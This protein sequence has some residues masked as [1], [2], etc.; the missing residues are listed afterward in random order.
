MKAWSLMGLLGLSLS[1]HAQIKMDEVWQPLLPPV[2]QIAQTLQMHPEQQLTAQ[3]QAIWSGKAAQQ[4]VGSAAWVLKSGV[5][6]RQLSGSS[7]FEQQLGAEKRLRLPNKQRADESIANRQIQYAD[8]LAGETSHRISIGLLEDWWLLVKRAQ[9]GRRIAQYQAL[10]Q[11]QADSVQKR[12]QAGDAARLELMLIQAEIQQQAL[13]QQRQQAEL[14]QQQLRLSRYYQGELPA[15]LPHPVLSA[16]LEQQV[17]VLLAS[18]DHTALLE[19][20]AAQDHELQLAS[21]SEQ[22]LEQQRL[23]LALESRPDP[24]VSLGYSREQRGQ[25]HLISIGLSLPLASPAH[26]AEQA[27]AQAELTQAQIQ[28][29]LLR[30]QLQQEAT[31]RIEQLKHAWLARGQAKQLL[32]MSEQQQQ[33]LYRAYQLGEISLNDWLISAR[34]LIQAQQR[35]DEMEQQL[36]ETYSRLR[37]DQHQLWQ[38]DDGHQ[39]AHS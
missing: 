3:H 27:V 21:L 19:H 31:A 8:R 12:I 5:Q 24:S 20:I 2:A 13:E 11:K 32:L 16:A 28:T 25:E 38:D 26:R 17:S 22:T 23:R 36:L 15:T 7:S 6:L 9:Q 35:L 29:Q 4:R 10:L 30:R 34:Q 14:T 37:L 33:L 18:S 1:S 39:T